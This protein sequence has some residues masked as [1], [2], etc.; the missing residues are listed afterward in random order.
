MATVVLNMDDFIELDSGTL[1]SHSQV[2]R[3]GHATLRVSISSERSY[4]RVGWM[5]SAQN[6]NGGAP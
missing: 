1:F 6:W 5:Y 3:E 2:G 4:S